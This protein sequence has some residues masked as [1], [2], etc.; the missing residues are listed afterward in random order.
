MSRR[1]TATKLITKYGPMVPVLWRTAGRPAA[2]AAQRAIAVRTARTTALRHA[3]TVDQGAILKVY[4]EGHP[5]WV[6]FSAAT[7][8][9]SYPPREGKLDALVASAD[10]AKKMTPE[11]FRARQA[12]RS[13]RRR[14]LWAARDK[15]TAWRRG[16]SDF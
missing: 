14:A 10:L 3:E 1:T 7:I 15:A 8:V 6:V 2:D 12:E 4:D 13:R 9:T 16:R 5:V 11:Q